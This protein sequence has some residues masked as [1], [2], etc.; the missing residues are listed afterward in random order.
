MIG[1]YYTNEIVA[2]DHQQHL[3]SQADVFRVD[4]AREQQRVLRRRAARP[5]LFVRLARRLAVVRTASL[6]MP[7][8]PVASAANTSAT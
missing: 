5:P 7:K 3:R 2:A 8:A 1:H 4:Q 6:E